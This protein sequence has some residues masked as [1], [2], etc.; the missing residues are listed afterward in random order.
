M[1]SVENAGTSRRCGGVGAANAPG[2]LEG[3]T[4]WGEWMPP[5][6]TL[7]WGESVRR[8][9]E[10]RIRPSPSVRGKDARASPAVPHRVPQRVDTRNHAIFAWWTPH[11]WGPADQSTVC[12]SHTVVTQ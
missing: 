6:A 12:M 9:H 11:N 4:H 3:D 10:L 7:D 2:K 1:A 5:H 8:T